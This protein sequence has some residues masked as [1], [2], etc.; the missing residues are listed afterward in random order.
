MDL[1][2]DFKNSFAKY[3]AAELFYEGKRE[4]YPQEDEVSYHDMSDLLSLDLPNFPHKSHMRFLV[5]K[6]RFPG[7]TA[8]P[9]GLIPQGKG[10]ESYLFN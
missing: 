9:L 2:Y 8:D 7:P 3:F 6:Y 4:E 1:S 10:L 5:K